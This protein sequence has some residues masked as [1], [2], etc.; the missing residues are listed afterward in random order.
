M[1]KSVLSVVTAAIVGAVMAF[2]APSW[3]QSTFALDGT[4]VNAV[5]AS[6]FTNVTVFARELFGEGSS[7]TVL[8]VDASTN[9][10]LTADFSGGT[11]TN[12]N[13]VVVDREATFTFRLHDGVQFA[14]DVAPLAFSEGGTPQPTKI[15]LAGTTGGEKGDTSVAYK[16]RAEVILN[17]ASSVFT[18]SIPKLQ[19]ASVL[20]NAAVGDVPPTVRMTVTVLP[21]TG[22]F[23]PPNSFPTYP[24]TGAAANSNVRVLA[25]SEIRFPPT[26]TPTATTPLSERTANI[27]LQDRTSFVSGDRVE[28]VSG[29]ADLGFSADGR[30]ALKIATLSIT[31]TSGVNGPDA[32]LGSERAP[33]TATSGD[34][35]NISARGSFGAGDILFLSRDNALSTTGGAGTRDTILTITGTTATSSAPLTNLDDGVTR[36]L[37]L[38]PAADSPLNRGLFTAEFQVDFAEESQRGQQAQ[39]PGV[40][41]EYANLSVLGYAYAIPNPNSSDIGNLRIRCESATNCSVFLDCRDQNGMAVGDFPEITLMPKATL[42]LNTKSIDPQLSLAR[43]LGVETWPGRLSCEFLTNADIGVQI[44]T[45]SDGTLVNNTYISGT[46]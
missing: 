22:R 42:V 12:A 31:P 14:E 17:Q 8:T 10:T 29:P 35:V 44:L 3:A 28:V 13:N 15:S 39:T 25:K 6:P 23:P 46:E 32:T 9:L 20:G 2:A 36:T 18:F 24:S 7:G 19:N 40:L 11:P 43:R 16:V 30:P 5:G 1:R 45:R 26:V 41:V 33:L 37:Y 4:T 34:M 38:V 27:N 21:T